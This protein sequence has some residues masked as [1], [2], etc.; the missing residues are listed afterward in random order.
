[1]PLPLDGVVPPL[2]LVAD[3]TLLA[4]HPFSLSPVG[5][6][7]SHPFTRA[8]WCLSSSPVVRIASHYGSM[9]ARR[10]CVLLPVYTRAVVCV[11][12]AGR[13]YRVTCRNQ[14]TVP[15][16][17]GQWLAPNQTN[18]RNN[19]T[20]QLYHH[21]RSPGESSTTHARTHAQSRSSAARATPRGRSASRTAL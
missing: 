20:V 12:L 4:S 11:L 17:A 9:L 14:S 6:A 18:K 21:K 10:R 1:M 19:S 13:P 2:R 15:S 16:E 7:F 5:G 8:Q 3:D